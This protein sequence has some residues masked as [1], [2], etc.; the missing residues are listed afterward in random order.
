MAGATAESHGLSRLGTAEEVHALQFPPEQR[1]SGTNKQRRT[2]MHTYWASGRRA[3]VK[4]GAPVCFS[5]QV[6]TD[7]GVALQQKLE[8]HRS[9]VMPMKLAPLLPSSGLIQPV[10]HPRASVTV[11]EHIALLRVFTALFF[12]ESKQEKWKYVLR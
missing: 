8:I 9:E 10:L 4:Q 3:P 2:R 11:W 1:T 6:V 5:G 12:P 7:E